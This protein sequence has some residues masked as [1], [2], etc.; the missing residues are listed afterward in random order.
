MKKIV[1]IFFLLFVIYGTAQ[2]FFKQD[3]RAH[4]IVALGTPEEVKSLL[5]SG[6]NVNKV[7]ECNTLLNT[8]IK[9][10]VYGTHMKL[11]PE[12]ALEKIKILV[13]AGADINIVPCHGKS[14]S[15]LDWAITL[16]TMVKNIEQTANTIFDQM[17]HEGTGECNLPGVVSKPCKNITAE[18]KKKMETALHS[19]YTVMGKLWTPCFMEIIRYLVGH[20]ANIN[21]NNANGRKIAPIHLA[22]TNS[23]EITL[24]PLKYLIQQGVDINIQ[25]ANGNT[26]LFYAYGAQNEKAIRLLQLAGANENIKNKNGSLYNEI[27]A[28]HIH[29][30]V[31]KNGNIKIQDKL[32]KPQ[33]E[34]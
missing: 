23:D 28:T 21:G 22:A 25:D 13:E 14:M 7:Y 2:A 6:Y 33:D 31:D 8:A 19:A 34:L 1:A 32:Y 10:A 9:S 20:G 4:E 29:T 30:I 27:T 12:F 11:P 16:P 5:Q 17:I 15:A 3:E 24:E 26:P 18:D